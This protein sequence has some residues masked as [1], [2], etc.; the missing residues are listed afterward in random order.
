MYCVLNI[1]GKSIVINH[2]GTHCILEIN[3][4]GACKRYELSMY[5]KNKTIRRHV[6]N[7]GRS[8]LKTNKMRTHK[9]MGEGGGE[10]LV[11]VP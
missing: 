2:G 7:I 9:Q 11:I 8:T 4:I 3:N 10:G 5:F 1:F 6:N